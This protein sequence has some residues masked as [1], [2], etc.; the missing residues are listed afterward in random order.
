MVNLIG[1]TGTSLGLS[2]PMI[3]A[4]IAKLTGLSASFV[5]DF[6]S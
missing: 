6:V 5:L 3:S 2:T 1:G 4:G